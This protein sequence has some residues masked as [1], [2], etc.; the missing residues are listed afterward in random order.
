MGVVQSNCRFQSDQ[1][2]AQKWYNVPKIEV[3]LASYLRHIRLISF[4]IGLQNKKITII[5]FVN[6]NE[7]ISLNPILLL[8]IISAKSTIK[9]KLG[10]YYIF[11]FGRN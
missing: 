4:I 2:L 6:R 10:K 5:K 7:I 1:I 8:T 11:E 3:S 9:E